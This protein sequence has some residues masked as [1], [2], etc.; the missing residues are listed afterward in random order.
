MRFKTILALLLL[1]LL[2]AGCSAD[3]K[4]ALPDAFLETSYTYPDEWP[5]NRFT[6]CIPQPDGCT[7]E[8]V[9]DL[10]SVRALRAEP[11]RHHPRRDARVYPQA[12]SGRLP[13]SRRRRKRAFGRRHAAARHGPA[14]RKLVGRLARHAHHA[15]RRDADRLTSSDGNNAAQRLALY[16]KTI[17]RPGVRE[18]GRRRGTP[19][20]D[21]RDSRAARR[22]DPPRS[23]RGRRSP[24]A[25]LPLPA[26]RT[27]PIF[28]AS[29]VPQRLFFSAPHKSAGIG[30][31]NLRTK[32]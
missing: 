2:L 1:A 24:A 14:E 8:S 15:G 13:Q 21:L 30:P 29:A 17:Y 6:D 32:G 7:V 16:A 4:D 20:A 23:K 18:A 31:K 10:S 22:T 19:P 3:G 27:F 11:V 26:P 5:E 28:L 12:G 25:A 9:R